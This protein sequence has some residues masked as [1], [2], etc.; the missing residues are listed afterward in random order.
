M[1][2]VTEAAKE[3]GVDPK[4]IRNAIHGGKLAATRTGL[5]TKSHLRIDPDVW[6]EYKR[7][8]TVVTAALPACGV[9]GA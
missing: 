6:A 5:G 1:P 7:A 2:T 4:T 8:L 9:G 3:L